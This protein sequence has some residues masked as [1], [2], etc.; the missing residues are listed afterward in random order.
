MISAEDNTLKAS[1]DV[2]D[3][4]PLIATTRRTIF[5]EKKPSFPGAFWQRIWDMG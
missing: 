2:Y 1:K 5:Q 4:L 3:D